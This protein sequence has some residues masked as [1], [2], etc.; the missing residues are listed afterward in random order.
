MACISIE[1]LTFLHK[2]FQSALMCCLCAGKM[3]CVL[4]S[5]CCQCFYILQI[6][7]IKVD[8]KPTFAPLGLGEFAPSPSDCA[9]PAEP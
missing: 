8:M 9:A 3:T 6:E 2:R 1:F 7:E 5:L 4:E